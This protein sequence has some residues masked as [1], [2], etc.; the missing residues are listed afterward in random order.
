MTATANRALQWGALCTLGLLL[1]AC[2]G[3]GGGGSGGGPILPG[4][5]LDVALPGLVSAVAGDG[6]ARVWFERPNN[7]DQFA[8]FVG[9]SS[10][11]LLAGAPAA[12]SPAGESFEFAG[13]SNGTSYRLALGT[14]P[15]SGS[16]WTRSGPILSVRPGAPIYV[17]PA[18]NS[19]GADGLTPATAF[20]QPTQGLV[21]ATQAS[22]NVWLLGGDYG[23]QALPVFDGLAVYGGFA[24]GFVL[25]ERDPAATPTVLR[26]QGNNSLVT[27]APAGQG[28]VLDGLTLNGSGGSGSGLDSEDTPFE[29]R[30]LSI[31]GCG[32]RGI[33]L[34]APL[35]GDPVEVVL[36]NVTANNN[37]ADGL[38]GQGVLDLEMFLCRFQGNVQE[39]ADFDD[40]LADSGRLGRLRLSACAF[41][42][43]A[44]EGLD[45]DLAAAL[46]AVPPGGDFSLELL[47]CAFELN[48]LAGLLLDID[49]ETNPDWNTSIQV[50]G[51]TAR[52][53][54]GPGARF[55]LDSTQSS[56]V[57]RCRFEGNQGEGLLVTSES[58]PGVCVVSA[59]TIAGNQGGGSAATLGNVALLWSHVVAEG[60]LGFGFSSPVAASTLTSSAYWQQTNPATGIPAIG[61]G[62]A[63]SGDFVRVARLFRN[64]S[65]VSSDGLTLDSSSDVVIG[66]MLELSGDG[67]A[68]AIQNVVGNQVTLNPAPSAF[69]APAPVTIFSAGSVTEDHRFNSGASLLGSGMAPSG[70]PAV[71]PGPAGS[72]EGLEPGP[73][74]AS[75]GAWLRLARVTPA[76][77]AGALSSNALVVLEFDRALASGSVT[78]GSVR[79]FGPADQVLAPV[80]SV[81]S[82]NLEL[83]AP[84]GGW[85]SSVRLELDRALF[86]S[87]GTPH[88]AP[89]SL[90]F[91]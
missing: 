20:P 56:F 48:G 31:S 17:D 29:A 25:S 58:L 14:R 23:A 74:G 45:V 11:G 22:G 53:N 86:A 3:G 1:G 46:G 63:Q 41:V 21:A 32:D 77:S 8:L 24:A 89:L 42:G 49:Y 73:L 70:G 87:D 6:V 82:G 27:V 83:S 52:A 40:L 76:L 66:D 57:H 39:G 65:G 61:S 37:G 54:R 91:E 9:T 71:D 15:D 88:A 36:A 10:A 80:L 55:D 5:T 79:A 69:T 72:P 90:R 68:R 67:V 51:C 38:S 18:A 43:N 81:N 60:N 64:S 2:G 30:S 12:L 35:S 34:R 13:L 84:V 19:Q 50:V 85:P 28:V 26:A 7:G 47:D 33:K 4:D 16:A 62:T 75:R 44:D 59:S 78:S